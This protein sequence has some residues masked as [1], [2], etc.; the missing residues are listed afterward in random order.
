MQKFTIGQ[1]AQQA[2]VN[3]K[4]VRFYERKGLVPER[5]RNA[6]G[7][8]QYGSDTVVR[9]HF[10]RRAKKLGFSLREINELLSL[11]ITRGRTCADVRRRAEA[12]VED[13]EKKIAALEELRNA[14]TR[15]VAECV[16]HGAPGAE[17]P[18]RRSG[19]C[20]NMPVSP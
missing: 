11:S 2:D 19:P 1:L 5:P 6:S 18:I 7:Y 20:R 12:K 16:D 8:R 14:L 15:L 10:I 9:M 4:T 17:C 3:I 13:I